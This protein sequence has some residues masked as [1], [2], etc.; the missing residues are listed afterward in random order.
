MYRRT[1]LTRMATGISGSVLLGGYA[2]AKA[3]HRGCKAGT[4]MI[5]IP[6]GFFLK[7]TTEETV[8]ELASKFGYHTSWLANESPQ[9][10][11]DLPDFQIDR[12]PVSNQSYYEFCKSTGHA[13]PKHWNRQTPPELLLDHP[14]RFVNQEDALAYAIWAGKRL[15]TENEWE[16]AARGTDGR[17]YPWGDEFDPN[18]CCWNRS[19]SEGNTTDSVHAHPSGAS[20]YGVM[21]MA[22]NLFEWCMDGPE[23]GAQLDRA[24]RF[25]AFLKG[26]AW[27]TTEVLDLRCAARGNSGHINNASSFYGFRCVKDVEL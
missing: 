26:G 16:K 9:R 6:S 3:N 8:K 5:H 23:G 11:V 15:P 24:V 4:E 19:G 18:A 2:M 12:Y 13:P 1:F 10:E 14:V 21:D 20:P 17:L 22:G 25:S 7:G 27:I